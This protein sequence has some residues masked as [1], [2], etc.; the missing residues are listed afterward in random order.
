MSIS[1]QKVLDLVKS[2]NFYAPLKYGKSHHF[3]SRPRFKDQGSGDHCDVTSRTQPSVFRTISLHSLITFGGFDRFRSQI[4]RIDVLSGVAVISE[5]CSS[6]IQVRLTSGARSRRTRS[7]LITLN[8]FF[9][10]FQFTTT[11]PFTY[12]L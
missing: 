3:G 10:A 5:S 4:C 12:V 11:I 9:A 7:L 1:S 8:R 6:V 2:L